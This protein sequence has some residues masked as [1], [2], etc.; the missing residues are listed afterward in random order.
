MED[1]RICT[2]ADVAIAPFADFRWQIFL[3]SFYTYRE[4][5]NALIDV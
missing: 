3:P 5:G 2:N 1:L 4:K